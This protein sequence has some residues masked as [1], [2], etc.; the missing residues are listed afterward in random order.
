MKIE[1]ADIHSAESQQLIAEL[2][3]EVDLIY[4]N[5]EPTVPDVSGM[6]GPDAVFLIARESGDAVGCVA[7][8]PLRKAIAEVKRM[9]VKPTARRRG[10]ARQ[11]M[12]ALEVIAR[13]KGF[14]EI[15]LETGLGQPAAIQL[16][17]NLGYTQISSFGDYAQDPVSVCYGKRL[18]IN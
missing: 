1:Q 6:E 8:R 5:R 16:Y 15:W 4:G 7:L 2:W 18:A 3:A 11:L 17:E 12:E 10:L 9:Y 13:E 14:R